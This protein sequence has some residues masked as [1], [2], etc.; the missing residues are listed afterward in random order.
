V[1]RDE[2]FLSRILPRPERGPYLQIY[3]GD[4]LAIT[5]RMLSERGLNS[6]TAA[7]RGF[8]RSRVDVLS[9]PGS[10]FGASISPRYSGCF[11]YRL[12]AT[13]VLCRRR[14]HSAC[15]PWTQVT[16]TSGVAGFKTVT[17]VRITLP[18][19]AS[20][21]CREIP[22]PFP[23]KYAKD[24]RFSRWFLIK[25]DR[26]ERT[27]QLRTGSLSRLFSGRHYSQSGFPQ[28]F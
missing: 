24:A 13:F 7:G 10:R 11:D 17:R 18:P 14:S 25:P 26:R 1:R 2:A 20:L 28:G 5:N 12:A 16:Q 9:A 15:I 8:W 3:W 23:S 4:Q 22:P 19:P 6:W 21:N 27:A